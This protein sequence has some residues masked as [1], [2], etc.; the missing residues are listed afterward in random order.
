LGNNKKK[1]IW[2]ILGIL[3]FANFISWI[4]VFDLDRVQFLEITFFDVGQGD[5]IF[6]E[7][8]N[9]NQILI[10]GGPSVVILE[11]LAGEMPF[12]DRT[13]EMVILTHPEADHLFGLLE[14][15]KSYKIENILWTGV[16][17]KTA[18]WKEWHN[19]IEK[20]GSNTKI[21]RAG[22]RIILQRKPLIY[23]DILNP[24][25]NLDGKEF[26][27]S[28]DSSIVAKLVFEKDSFLFTGD[29][30][31]KAEKKI[32]SSGAFLDSDVLKIAHHGSKTSTS[33]EF[34]ERVLPEIAVI[35]VGKDN[36]YGHPSP[37][38]LA[39]IEEFDI[40][41]LRTDKNGDIK[42]FSDGEKIIY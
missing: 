40:Q 29:I 21:A 35:Q 6:I 38:V 26:E 1:L 39:K 33:Q 31:E 24:L 20:E 2:I 14:V 37:E 34:L 19:L 27:D 18:K 3:I 30:T 10:D 9:K 41:C 15:L 16:V 32:I 17:R 13:I 28:N 36:S 11:K 42:I 7:L 25:E 12:Y 8:P 4:I 5:S 22:Q 23:L